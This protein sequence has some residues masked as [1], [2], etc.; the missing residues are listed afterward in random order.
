MP[1]KSKAQQR[2]MGAELA[3]KRA[4]KKTRTG[5]ST[6]QLEDFAHTKR[7]GLPARKKKR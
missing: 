7:K 4:G 3:R 6:K 1:A 5:M 2:F